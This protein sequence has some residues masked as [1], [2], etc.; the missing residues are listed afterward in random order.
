MNTQLMVHPVSSEAAYKGA[1]FEGV[2]DSG[3]FSVTGS[4]YIFTAASVLKQPAFNFGR[5]L[6]DSLP[7][8]WHVVQG[9]G[10]TV[11]VE[12]GDTAIFRFERPQAE[13]V[14]QGPGRRQSPLCCSVPVSAYTAAGDWQGAGLWLASSGKVALPASGV[15]TYQWKDSATRGAAG[16]TAWPVLPATPDPDEVFY[17]CYTCYPPVPVDAINSQS[18]TVDGWQLAPLVLQYTC[19]ER[20]GSSERDAVVQIGDFCNYI[21]A[22]F[23]FTFIVSGKGRKSFGYWF[24]EQENNRGA[25]AT[26]PYWRISVSQYLG[27][28]QDV[29]GFGIL[30]GAGGVS[31][32]SLLVGAYAP[33]GD[34]ANPR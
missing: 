8:W 17:D 16:Y 28:L 20:Y 3:S 5:V 4:F 23:P 15:A 32:A 22:R 7:R 12:L 10:Q 31:R 19:V 25:A 1:A 27:V 30:G 33:F 26:H 34:T 2:A 6:R 14:M 13:G 29:P 24:P 21:A 11:E 9:V 18:N